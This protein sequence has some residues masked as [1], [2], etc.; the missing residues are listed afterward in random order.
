MDSIGF[1]GLGTMGSRNVRNLLAGGYAPVIYD[2]NDKAVDALTAEGATAAGS[3]RE[4]AQRVDVLFLSLPDS[5]QVIEV[6]TGEDGISAG[7]REGLIVIDLSTVAPMTPQRLAPELA[8]LGITWL[9]APVSG[10]PAGAQAGTLTI[11]LGGDEA[12]VERCRPIL[13]TIGK[14]IEYMGPSGMGATTKI[15]N[16]LAIGVQ[17]LSMF[18]AFTLG[19][20]AGIDA[21]RLFE[22][23]RTSSSSCWVMEN[24]V[25]SVVLKNTFDDPWFALRL[26]HKDLRIAL[27]TARALDVPA[28]GA[29]LSE[30]MFAIAESR[31]WGDLDHMTVIKLYA[32]WAGI[33]EW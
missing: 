20:K 24:L 9:D 33:D 7:A 21:N 3:P 8:P 18:E 5:P 23:L 31:G 25:K 32:D 27:D 10:G 30:Q 6:A 19:V 4:V 1:V 14:N 13:E 17:M 29:A 16:Q 12:A 2:V 15:V 28:A 26:M 22:V 11:M